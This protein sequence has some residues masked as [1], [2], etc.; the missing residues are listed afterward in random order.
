VS[1][2][3]AA[4]R[5]I[6]VGKDCISPSRHAEFSTVD[7]FLDFVEL[8]A[9]ETGLPVTVKS[10][11]GELRFW[12]E[13]ADRMAS[14][15]RGVDGITID[16]GEGGTGPRRWCSPTTSPCRSARP[17]RG[18]PRLRRARAAR[19]DRL[20]ALGQGRP[21]RPRAAGD[22]DGRRPAA[23]R[24]RADAVDRLHPGQEVPHRPLPHRRRDPVGLA[25]ARPGP[26]AQGGPLRE[27]RQTLR[28]DLLKVAQAAGHD[29]PALLTTDD[30]EMLGGNVQ[31]QSGSVL[32]G[33]PAEWGCRRRPT[34]TP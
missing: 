33:Y 26:D 15:T 16:G 12:E 21:A 29:H 10:A 31:W 13:L 11:V 27:L 4:T 23:R 19:A 3:I 1:A 14:G 32:T 28:R 9:D 24:P 7:G 6:A 8:L 20:G 18:L 5:G 30:L 25:L 2:E 34:A 17:S 22:G